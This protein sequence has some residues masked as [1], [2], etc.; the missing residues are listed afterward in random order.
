MDILN[1]T[2][3]V[4]EVAEEN[5]NGKTYYTH[6]TEP[7]P[8]FRFVSLIL[9]DES[10]NEFHLSIADPYPAANCPDGYVQWHLELSEN[11]RIPVGTVL[12]FKRPKWK[13]EIPASPLKTLSYKTSCTNV[14]ELWA[15]KFRPHPERKL[16]VHENGKVRADEYA[17][18]TGAVAK[19]F[20]GTIE[21]EKVQKFF[22]EMLRCVTDNN[23]YS[24]AYYDDR[25]RS[26]TLT[27]ESGEK[28]T[29][30]EPLTNGDLDS[31][32]VFREFFNSLPLKSVEPRQE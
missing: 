19:H 8:R 4:A 24:I 21:K 31:D 2:L 11:V 17:W 12:H 18:K 32:T 25:G 26:F 13:K 7:T 16:I 5:Y 23:F 29:Y 3:T 22:H 15:G 20:Q 30:P 10:G 27:F 9:V 1:A 28:R 6:I 14:D